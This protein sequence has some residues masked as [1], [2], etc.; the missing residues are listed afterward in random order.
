MRF[1]YTCD[2]V[3]VCGFV[4]GCGLTTLEVRFVYT[5]MCVC[6][7]TRMPPYQSIDGL[8]SPLFHPP[9]PAGLATVLALGGGAEEKTTAGPHAAATTSQQKKAAAEEEEGEGETPVGAG[10]SDPVE[11]L[12]RLHQV[13]DC[14]GFGE[15]VYA[16]MCVSFLFWGIGVCMHA[17]M[18]VCVYIDG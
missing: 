3:W 6:V 11:V 7:Y 17:Y 13:C 15:S 5:C 18:C 9:P 16:Y 2:S 8:L 12:A 10:E 14:Y 1:V 4:G